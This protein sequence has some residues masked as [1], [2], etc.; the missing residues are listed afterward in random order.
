MRN[1]VTP[2]LRL[3]QIQASETA[4]HAHGVAGERGWK[5]QMPL[6]EPKDRV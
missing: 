4:R 5:K 1:V 2:S 6:G 3:K